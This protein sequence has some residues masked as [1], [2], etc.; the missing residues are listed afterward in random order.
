MVGESELMKTTDKNA[1]IAATKDS[2]KVIVPPQGPA[3][4]LTPDDWISLLRS[5]DSDSEVGNAA[6]P[7]DDK[8]KAKT[9]SDALFEKLSSTR[10]VRKRPIG[11]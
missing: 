4:V 6:S 2:K 5:L 1:E 9:A 10:W 7:P 11:A 3:K 8:A